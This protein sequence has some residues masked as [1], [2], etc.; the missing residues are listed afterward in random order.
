MRRGLFALGVFAALPAT[1][2]AEGVSPFHM[3]RADVDIARAH[4]AD[5]ATWDGEGFV[6]GDD[7]KLWVKSEGEVRDGGAERAEVQAL[8]SRNVA[9]FWDAQAGL[10]VDLEPETTTYLTVG[11]EG[12]A[13]YGFETD[14]AL[15]VREDGDV[16]AR[17]RQT[18]DILITQRLILEPHIEVN[19]YAR[20]DR[21]RHV[22]AGLAEAEAGLQLRHEITRQVAPYLDI[23]IRRALGETA[24]LARVAGE[25]ADETT[26]RAGVR[27]WF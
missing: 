1:A 15:F 20:D 3:V 11:V 8:W 10:R 4:G 2:F 6:G 19:A 17:F 13:P 16:S 25:D 23:N 12:L 5:M 7:D 18:L 9:P 22:G 24:Q 26:L 14:A 21:A 27:L